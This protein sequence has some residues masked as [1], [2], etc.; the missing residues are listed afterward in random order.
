MSLLA[1]GEAEPEPQPQ[2]GYGKLRPNQKA[3]GRRGGVKFFDSA[4]WAMKNGDKQGQQ[5]AEQPSPYTIAEGENQAEGESPLA[6]ASP[7][8]GN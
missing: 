1:G 6:N 7:L 2:P 8:S 3:R 5:P 4:D